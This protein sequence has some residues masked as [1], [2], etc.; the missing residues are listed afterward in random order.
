MFDLAALRKLYLEM[1]EE[2]GVVPDSYEA[3][4]LLLEQIHDIQTLGIVYEETKS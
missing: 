4:Y 2:F 3:D 1:C